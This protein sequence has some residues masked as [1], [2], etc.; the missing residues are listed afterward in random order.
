MTRMPKMMIIITTKKYNTRTFP[1]RNRA[2]SSS[3]LRGSKQLS[4]L[5][6]ISRSRI[7]FKEGVGES[8][9]RLSNK[10]C[11]HAVPNVCDLKV[12][13][14]FSKIKKK[15]KKAPNIEPICVGILIF[16]VNLKTCVYACVDCNPI[17]KRKQKFQIESIIKTRLHYWLCKFKSIRPICAIGR[18]TCDVCVFELRFREREKSRRATIN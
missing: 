4:L 9:R 17:Q 11:V 16:N 3:C 8:M 2:S 1:P 15:R 12:R 6:I 7:D 18:I 5:S 13:R 14:Q 10:S